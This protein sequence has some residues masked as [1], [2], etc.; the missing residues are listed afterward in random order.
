MLQEEFL[1]IIQ[2]EFA[3]PLENEAECGY[4]EVIKIPF[5]LI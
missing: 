3:K 1:S 4:Q 5:T 2:K